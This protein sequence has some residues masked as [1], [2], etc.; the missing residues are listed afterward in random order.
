MLISRKGY[1]MARAKPKPKMRPKGQPPYYTNVEDMHKL[2]E[3]YFKECEGEYLFD[4]NGNHVFNKYGE[5]I[6]VKSKP[7]SV[8][9]LALK[10]GFTNRQSVL[11]Y[12]NKDEYFDTITRAKLRIEE[13]NNTRLYDKDGVQ[14]AKFNLTVNY[15]YVEKKEV[16]SDINLKSD[17]FIEALKNETH[18]VWDDD[19]DE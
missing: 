16:Q 5:P 18:K 7:P 10:L 4:Q 1:I 12:Q 8:A 19:E 15:G 2:I 6:V 14:G 17:G 11:N 13:Y 9:G 3:E